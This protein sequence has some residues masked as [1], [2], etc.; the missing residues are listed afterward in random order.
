MEE[1]TAGR[2]CLM[3]QAKMRRLRYQHVDRTPSSRD[4]N[5]GALVDRGANGGICGHDA[6]LISKSPWVITMRGL[7]HQEIPNMPLVTAGGV[8]NTSSGDAVAIMHQYAHL[9]QGRTIH[10]CGQMTPTTTT[11]GTR[12]M[13]ET[14]IPHICEH[15]KILFS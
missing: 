10:S 4:D 1:L 8:M 15:T 2:W 13:I 6:R 3:K 5:H 9:A 14:R 11:Q 12:A 7:D